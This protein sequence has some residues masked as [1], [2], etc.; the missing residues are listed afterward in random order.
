MGDL[1][2]LKGN[3][4]ECRFIDNMD[5]TYGLPAIGFKCYDLCLTDPPYNV[6]AKAHSQAKKKRVDHV[7]EYDDNIKNWDEFNLNWFNEV[8]RSAN[9][10]IFTPGHVN[11]QWWYRNTEP[12]DFIIH[13]KRNGHSITSMFFHSKQEMLL[14]YG[15]FPRKMFMNVHDISLLNG[16]RREEHW[17]HPHPK[18]RDLWAAIIKDVQ[19]TS[20]LDPFLGSGTTAEVCESLGIPWLGYEIMEEYAPDIEKRIQRGIKKKQQQSL[21]AWCGEALP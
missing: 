12:R 7:I 21:Q 11:I 16:F 20:V 5:E 2:I 10:L 8:T 9:C 6:N 4:G 17:D 15:K 1:K 13:F 18:S 3:Y 19:P 14:C